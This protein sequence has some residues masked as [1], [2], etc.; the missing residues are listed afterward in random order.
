MRDING[1]RGHQMPTKTDLNRAS[2]TGP[3]WLKTTPQSTFY[4]KRNTK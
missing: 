4:Q 3:L 1:H 2:R